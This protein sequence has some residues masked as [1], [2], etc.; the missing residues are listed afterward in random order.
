MGRVRSSALLAPAV[1]CSHHMVSSSDDELDDLELDYPTA[2]L[3]QNTG[4][5]MRLEVVVPVG[6]QPGEAIRIRTSFG[7]VN[8][9]VPPGLTGRKFCVNL[10]VDG[11]KDEEED[12][13]EDEDGRPMPLDDYESVHYVAREGNCPEA[14]DSDGVACWALGMLRAKS[15]EEAGSPEYSVRL[16]KAISRD[17]SLASMITRM[18]KVRRL[19]V[20]IHV[21]TPNPKPTPH[22]FGA[23][24]V[25]AWPQYKPA[26]H[27]LLSVMATESR[28]RF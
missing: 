28:C 17:V 1:S 24:E 19:R 25:C 13:D 27:V 14:E 7:P 26:V 16:D 4:T 6:M 22:E 2:K 8:V 18:L 23:Q 3:V 5:T 11:P 12:E 10:N 15:P 20:T 21:S 9:T